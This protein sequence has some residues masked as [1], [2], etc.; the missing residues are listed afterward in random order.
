[1]AS[2]NSQTST[3][4]QNVSTQQAL[5]LLAQV[6]GL[7]LNAAGDVTVP[8]INATKY[9]VKEVFFANCSISTTLSVASFGI[10][11]APA[12]AGTGVLT[13]TLLSVITASTVI[14]DSSPSTTAVQ[15]AQQLYFR[16][17]AA[18]GAASTIDV[19]VYGFD[20]S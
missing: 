20:C 9:S 7:N 5:R 10:F 14:L 16:V 2:P 15:T 4:T 1:M 11:T 3:P 8:I 19:S 13:A 12:S 6:K 17:I 18:Q